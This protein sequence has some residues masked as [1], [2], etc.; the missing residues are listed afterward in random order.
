PDMYLDEFQE[1]LWLQHGVI[2]GISTIWN[3][4]TEL[5]L[6]QKKLSKVAAECSATACTKFMHNIAEEL[7][8]RLVFINKGRVDLRTTYRLNG[9]A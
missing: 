8:E 5:G 9:W 2:I 6:S 3:T 1:Q 7:P 4:L